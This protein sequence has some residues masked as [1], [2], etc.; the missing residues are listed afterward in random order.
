MMPG[1]KNK[2]KEALLA[3]VGPQGFSE[4]L[5]DMVSYS[6]DASEHSHRPQAAVWPQSAQEVA[7]ILS[8]ADRERLPVVPRGAGTGLAGAVVPVRGGLVMDLARMNRIREI[9]L[10]DR[11]VVVEPGVVFAQLQAELAPSGFSFPPD[12]ASGKVATLG[13]NVAT[14]AGGLQGAKYG[15]TRDYVLGLEVA[16]ADGS[17]MRTGSRCMKSV[18][19]YDLTGLIVGSEGT[20]GVVTEITLKV[21]PKPPLSATASASFADLR[22]AGDAIRRIM[23]S[24][25]TPSVLEILDAE[26]IKVLNRHAGQ[27]LPEAA[28]MV[29]AE[30]DGY[31]EEETGYQIRQITQAFA[32]HD[33]Q[34]IALAKSP[35]Q[36]QEFWAAR[37]AIGGTLFS[38]NNTMLAEDVTV[39]LS[40]V[41]EM[42]VGIGEVARRNGVLI[43]TLG[44]LGDG[45]L[46]PNLI[47]DGRDPD[48][49]SRAHRAAAELFALAVELGG[50]LTGEH[51]IGLAKAPFMP[52]EHDEAA[53]RMMREIKRTFDPHNILNP[54]KMGL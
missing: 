25:F 7:A 5:I 44:H 8:L 50:T 18:S 26:C 27:N 28:A 23:S 43:A 36:A 4:A 29:L 37:K 19:G 20:L 22:Q 16:L 11:L 9:S 17:L 41:T 34:N 15:V 45:N 31:T 47:I 10:A 12:P 53:M 24:R 40:K 51:G 35:E 38:L 13:G 14:N 6:G 49:L 3:I 52:L 2:L 54:G 30:A 33:A 32:E 21:V 46:H 1:L 39:P 42:L 48:Q